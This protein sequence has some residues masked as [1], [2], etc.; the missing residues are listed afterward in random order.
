MASAGR[1][2]FFDTLSAAVLANSG[3]ESANKKVDFHSG[4]EGCAWETQEG[5]HRRLKSNSESCVSA[6]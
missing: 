1:K 5:I 3:T 6:V 2:D 4:K